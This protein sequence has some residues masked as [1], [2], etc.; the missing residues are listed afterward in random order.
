MKETRITKALME[1]AVKKTLSTVK[2]MGENYIKGICSEDEFFR[3]TY[4]ALYDG[5]YSFLWK[6]RILC[7]ITTDNYEQFKNG[8]C[9][10]IQEA[11]ISRNSSDNNWLYYDAIKS[12]NE[13]VNE[14]IRN[15]YYLMKAFHLSPE[16]F[17][18]IPKDVET[19]QRHLDERNRRVIDYK[20]DDCGLLEDNNPIG[21]KY[22]YIDDRGL[23][24]ELVIKEDLRAANN[25]S[26]FQ[27][28][29][30]GFIEGYT[31]MERNED[32]RIYIGYK[33]KQVVELAYW[34]SPEDEKVYR[35]Y[36][37]WKDYL[38]WIDRQENANIQAAYSLMENYTKHNKQ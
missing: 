5:F 13:A 6:R 14:D 26:R 23:K 16:A 35:K 7:K 10:Y 34:E 36:P 33:D 4:N 18:P 19:P 3:E 25:N 12:G 8:Y 27:F 15:F 31:A 32:S 9:M 37:R 24:A 20:C 21:K 22:V 38:Y 2:C 30:D 17:I 1:N 29:A 28:L 11:N